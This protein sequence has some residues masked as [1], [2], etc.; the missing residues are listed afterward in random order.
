MNE[1]DD[2]SFVKQIDENENILSDGKFVKEIVEYLIH[3]NISDSTI[4]NHRLFVILRDYYLILLKQWHNGETF[5]ENRSFIFETISNL[6]LKMSSIL[7]DKNLLILKELI[8]N[9]ELI[10]EINRFLLDLSIT[11]KY[12]DDPQMK[13]LDN[14]FRTIQRF[15]RI[16]TKTD[17]LFSNIIKCICSPIFIE[18]FLQSINEENEHFGQRFLLNTCTD[19]IYSHSINKQHQQSLIDIRENILHPF[20]QWI[21][22]QSSNYRSWNNRILI[23]LR[24]ISFLLTLSIQFN[25]DLILE[26]NIYEDF[27]QLID[28][29][30]NILYSI[31]ELDN[32]SLIGTIIPN[33]Y[34]MT[35]SNQ[36]EKYFQTKHITLLILK[37][38]DFDNDEIQLNAFKILSIITI[39]QDT[40]NILYSNNLMKNFIKYLHEIIDDTNQTLT[41]HNLLQCLKSKRKFL[42]DSNFLFFCCKLDL[43]QYE[44]IKEEFIKQNG[45]TLILRCTTESKIQQPIFEIVLALTFHK[46]A[47][48]QLKENFKSS[49]TSFT[50]QYIRW[51]LEKEEELLSRPIIQNKE[52]KYDIILLYSYSDRD[53]CF[54]IYQELLKENFRVWIDQDENMINEKYEIIDSCEY[55]LICLSE[56]YKQNLYCQC[57]ASYAFQR[58]CQLIP[59]IVTSNYRPDGWLNPLINGKISIDFTKLDFELAKLKLKNQIDRQRK[60]SIKK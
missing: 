36:L 59:L 47:F 16:S 49:G 15:Q 30:I 43:I 54:R 53:L 32:K 42:I 1:H 33:L 50:L 45:L 40:K 14:L 35:L 48:Q 24:Q 2:L 10:D 5:D 44:Q 28:S 29:F 20:T 3:S 12:F 17:H 4:I 13:S 60:I 52:Y 22:Q 23:I 26:K 38:T 46:E 6:F 25:R 58:Q 31:I 41:F 9:P 8:F 19:Y 51:K 37:L 27:C 18:I 57:E 39:E 21:N 56:S 34:T 11:K 7:S 55:V